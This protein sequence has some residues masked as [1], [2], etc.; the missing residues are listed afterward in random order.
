MNKIHHFLSAPPPPPFSSVLHLLFS[1][2]PLCPLMLR[3]PL[4]LTNCTPDSLFLHFSFSRYP[5][6]SLHFL[7]LSSWVSVTRMKDRKWNWIL[8]RRAFP[9]LQ[10]KLP[11]QYLLLVLREGRAIFCNVIGNPVTASAAMDSEKKTSYMPCQHRWEVKIT[12]THKKEKKK[13]LMCVCVIFLANADPPSQ[14]G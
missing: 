3:L 2:L 13:S 11:N 5:R 10:V 7:P 1:P 9:P 4:S 14:P 6:L 8:H 12:H